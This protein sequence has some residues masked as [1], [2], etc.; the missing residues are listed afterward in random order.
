MNLKENLGAGWLEHGKGGG[1][2][3]KMTFRCLPSHGWVVR[4]SLEGKQVWGEMVLN[5]A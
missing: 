2:M 5:L 3:F 1:R 4:P